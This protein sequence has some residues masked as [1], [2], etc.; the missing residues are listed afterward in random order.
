MGSAF[1][2]ETRVSELDQDTYLD[3][4]SSMQCSV[5]LI[6]DQPMVAE[7]LRRVIE[8]EN[9]I[10]FHY[11]Q[12]PLDA[13]A[14]AERLG[15]D[16]ILLDL[17]MPDV[18]GAT[19]LRYLRANPK[20]VNVPVVMLSTKEDP[21]L[22]AEAFAEGANDYLIKWP[23]SVELLARIRYH[24]WSYIHMLERDEAF[25]ALRESQKKLADTNLELRRLAAAANAAT[26]AKSSFLAAMSHDI[27][28]PMNAILGTAE[29]MTDTRLDD[30]QRQ[31]VNIISQAGEGLLALINDILDLS[32]IEAG[33]LDLELVPFD[34]TELVRS[35]VEMMRTSS[36][37]RGLELTASFEDGLREKVIGDPQ[38]LRQV[39]LNLLGNA[40]KFT[41]SGGVY[42]SVQQQD[43]DVVQVT[44]K[45]TGIGVPPER[46]E[47]IFKPFVQGDRT[48]SRR[49]G[50]SG[51]GL[52]ICRRLVEK[53]DGHIWVESA[54]GE[55]S[56]FV[57]TA[58]LP[59]AGADAQVEKSSE[60]A[61][62]TGISGDARKA[63]PMDILLV[64]DNVTNQFIVAS[65][66]RKGGYQ[67]EI[68]EDG[69]VAVDKFKG[70]T[71]D[72]V[73]MDIEMPVMDGCTATRIIRE[74]EMQQ[75]RAATP[76]IAL[77]ANAMREDTERALAAGC[78]RH[79]S[80][81][82][83]RATLLETVRIY[84]PR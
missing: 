72:I 50:G 76:I 35:T 77:T 48:T 78:D 45:D 30:E 14:E 5:L 28:T 39:L 70:G 36:S 68:A 33:Q 6:D 71:Y 8:S 19:L 25:R 84:Q 82:V 34:L 4:A 81:P 23:D 83:H 49:F 10:L 2:R 55:G 42:V 31:Y 80:K 59:P 52:S 57:F 73:F 18:D 67:V 79:L 15:P 43:Y 3:K 40:I 62:A 60:P 7:A 13:V 69:Q 53:M 12:Q 38:R 1:D 64:E 22:K 17:V 16:L 54:E 51:L 27:R 75:N 11:C 44:V 46:Q 20:T 66:L 24:S 32:K 61:G 58:H 41:Q 63:S 65:I 74:W 37:R 56:S 9:D 21:I 29:L 26:K 47:T